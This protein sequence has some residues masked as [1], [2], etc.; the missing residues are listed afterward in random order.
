MPLFRKIVARLRPAVEEY[1]D[2]DLGMM[3]REGGGAWCGEIA[4]NHRP[5]GD[6]FL[7]L[8][9]EAG[10]GECRPTA[11]QRGFVREIVERYS[12]VWPRVAGALAEAHPVHRTVEAVAEHLQR[13]CLCLGPLP[14]G[15]PR[16]WSL[17]YTFDTP[18][19]GD[20]GYFVDLREWEVEGVSAVD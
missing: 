14:A 19:E 18:N 1:L 2:P 15:P 5:T 20:I 11:Q 4:L 17:Q 10:E 16:R 7:D 3:R 6:D 12:E 13:P 8:L 9:I